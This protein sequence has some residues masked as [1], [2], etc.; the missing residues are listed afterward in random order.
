MCSRN[1][2]FI[3]IRPADLGTVTLTNMIAAWSTTHGRSGSGV[4]TDPHT[5]IPPPIIVSWA[6]TSATAAQARS[7]PRSWS[8]SAPGPSSAIRPM[9]LYAV[10][11]T[12]AMR[13]RSCGRTRRSS[14]AFAGSVPVALAVASRRP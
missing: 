9:R 5:E 3:A 11:T 7:A 4:G 6:S 12:S 8:A 10:K 14:T 1:R 2:T 13:M